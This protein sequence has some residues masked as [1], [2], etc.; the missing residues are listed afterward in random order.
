MNLGIRLHDT[1]GSTLEEHLK[2]PVSRAF[3]AP[4]SP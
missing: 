2:A 1:A 3:P 4:T